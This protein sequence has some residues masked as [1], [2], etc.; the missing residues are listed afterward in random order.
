MLDSF[1]YEDHL[2]RRFVGLE[3][4][5]YLNY[6]DL[7]DY[8][9][10]HDTINGRIFRFYRGMTD[11]KIPLVVNCASDEEAVRVKNRLLE[12]A[13]ADIKAMLPGKVYIGDWYTNGFITT[14]KKSDY[15]VS[16]RLCSIEL[17]LTSEDP[18]WFK[19]Q[20]HRFLPGSGSSV[21]VG[22]GTDY[23]YDYR[24]DY[25]LSMQG[26]KV[27]TGSTED[28]AFR[29]QI[30]GEA[31][32]PAVVIGGHVYTIT[33]NV[34]RGEVLTVDSLN[35][36]ITLTTA[37]GTNI[38]WFDKRGRANYIFKPIPAGQNT[39]SWNGMFGFDLTVIEKRSEPEW[40]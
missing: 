5:V 36:T 31:V 28:S 16:R 2:G 17:T 23:R 18:V 11:R 21:G 37:S 20:T 13:E 29:L 25:A 8:T 26:Q 10:D 30:F 34:G 27:V 15:L 22:G 1:I 38:N 35:K 32:N 33:G 24:Y 40:T 14:S 9:W 39:V 7:R 12:L 4:H 19:E 3:N 6:N